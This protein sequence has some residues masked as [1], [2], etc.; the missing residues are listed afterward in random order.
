MTGMQIEAKWTTPYR[1]IS[2]RAIGQWSR[3]NFAEE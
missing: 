1:A 3:K 2:S